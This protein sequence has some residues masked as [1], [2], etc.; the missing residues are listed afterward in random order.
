TKNWLD[1]LKFRGSWT[2]SK[3]PADIYAINSSYTLNNA[4]WGTQNGASVPSSLYSPVLNPESAETF[5]Q[6]LQAMFLKNRV[7]LDVSHYTKRVFD[8]L[9]YVGLT[10]A[11][12]YGSLYTNFDEEITRRGWEIILNVTPVKN[13]NW[14]LDIGMNWSTYAS[15][16]TKI[17][18]VNSVKKPWVAVGERA[19]HFI[20]RDFLREPNGTKGGGSIVHNSSGRPIVHPYD[21][22]FGYYDPKFVWGANANLRYKDISL[23]ISFDGVSGGLANTRT[24]SYMWQAGVHP[25]SLS[26]E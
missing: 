21:V 13:K 20:S 12:G 24:E 15:Y 11:S 8:R 7:M 14:Q 25:N 10:S 5:E 26:P 1:F 23:F 3:R 16:Y 22:L 4:T 2:V 6:G 19:D 18:S 17:D 9:M